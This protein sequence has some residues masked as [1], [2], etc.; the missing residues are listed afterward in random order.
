MNTPEVVLQA[1]QAQA[2][3]AVVKLICELDPK[4]HHR[5]A[6]LETGQELIC[7][8]IR[9][10][11]EDA[12]RE[13]EASGVLRLQVALLEKRVAALDPTAP[14]PKRQTLEGRPLRLEDFIQAAHDAGAKVS[15]EIRKD[16]QP[17]PA[18]HGDTDHG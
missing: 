1:A 4:W 14:R 13:R 5:G 3:S 12:T 15:I 16:G 11:H 17:E 9:R 2:W 7:A 8:S 18:W 6:Q 10:M